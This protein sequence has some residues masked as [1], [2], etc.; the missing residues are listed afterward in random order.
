MMPRLPLTVRLTG[1]YVL[2]SAVLLLGMAAFMSAAITRHFAELDRDTLQDK[3]HLVQGLAAHAASWEQ[4]RERLHVALQ[5]HPGL[6]VRIDAGP[7]PALYAPADVEFPPTLLQQAPSA[8]HDNALVNWHDGHASYQGIAAPLSGPALP[9]QTRVIAAID[10]AHH[11][12]FLADLHQSL[13]L[14]LLLGVGVSGLLG[15]WAA[16]AGLR[17]L[18]RMQAQAQR[19]TA[20]RLDQRMDVEAIPPELANLAHSLNDMLQRLQGDF[21][22]LSDFS[23]DLAHE[24]RTPLNNLLTQTEVVLSRSRELGTYRDTLASNREELQRLARTVSDMLLLAKAENGSLAIPHPTTIDLAH[25]VQALFDFYEALAE[26]RQV[27]LVLQGQ[28]QVTGDALMLRRA[29]GNLLSNALRH[30]QAHS[31]IVV[32]LQPHPEG[33][34]HI[35]VR[36]QGDTIAPDVLPRLFDRFFRADKARVHLDSDGAGLGLSITQAIAQAHGGRVHAS[37]LAGCNTFTIELPSHPRL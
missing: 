14:Y 20:H 12:H 4:L 24:L 25:E 21:E 22:R 8:L 27:R 32:Q 18:R 1:W 11:A 31:D 35:G 15:W 6:Y 19:V 37:S 34:V 30:A 28:A 36:N 3:I 26:D 17:P 23:S 5:N 9:D 33:G 16:R 7:G 13:W 10:T 2:A 29:I